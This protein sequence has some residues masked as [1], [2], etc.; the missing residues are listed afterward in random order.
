[1]PGAEAKRAPVPEDVRAGILH[2]MGLCCS[3]DRKVSKRVIVFPRKQEMKS[4][5][6][7]E[8]KMNV[9]SLKH[10]QK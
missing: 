3:R 1:M 4:R 7:N 8:G 9:A 5:A 6:G 2:H 10:E